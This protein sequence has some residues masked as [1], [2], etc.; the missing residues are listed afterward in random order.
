MTSHNRLGVCA[1]LTLVL[2]ASGSIA[3]A[4]QGDQGDQSSRGVDQGDQDDQGS[5]AVEKGDQQDRSVQGDDQGKQGS[6]ANQRNQG[7]GN[8]PDPAA[9]PEL[10][11][12]VLYAIGLIGVATPLLFVRLRRRG[13][14]SQPTV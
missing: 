5:R 10:D 1:A 3:H 4:Q 9:T 8:A 7:S 6:Q 11:T 12:G 13:G 2:A 14:K